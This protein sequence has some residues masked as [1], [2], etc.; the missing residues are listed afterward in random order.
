MSAPELSVVET[1]GGGDGMALPCSLLEVTLPNRRGAQRAVRCPSRYGREGDPR[2]AGRARTQGLRV[3]VEQAVTANYAKSGIEEE[4]LD[5]VRQNGK[6]DIENLTPIDLAG[7]D[8][9][10]IGG[11]SATLVFGKSL[12]F[13][14]GARILDLGCGIGGPARVIAEGLKVDVTGIDLVE[15]FIVAASGLTRRCRL[16]DRVRFLRASALATPFAS[17]TFDGA[18]M[19]A[20]GMNVADKPALFREARRVLKPG[21]RLGVCDPMLVADAPGSPSFPLPWGPAETSFLELPT[22]YR[23]HIEAAGFAIEEMTE[24]GVMARRFFERERDRHR[25]GAAQQVNLRALLGED[26]TRRTANISAAVLA[27]IIAPVEIIAR[28]V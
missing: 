18:Y 6:S 8:E 10:H 15:D 2:S 7:A 16:A 22:T 3:S 13:T 9:L 17:A 25:D 12:G 14:P 26:V 27:G 4:V 20:L 28:A 23:A 11:L 24:R 5:L 21:A 1:G 19:I